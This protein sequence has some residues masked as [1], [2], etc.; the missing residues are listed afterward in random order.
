MSAKPI[1]PRG[2]S[3]RSRAAEVHNLSEKVGLQFFL[4]GG[5]PILLNALS[6]RRNTILQTKL[7][8]YVKIP[9]PSF[10]NPNSKFKT[11]SYTSMQSEILYI[12]NSI[13]ILLR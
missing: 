3:K 11:K 7:G 9:K 1:P 8:G 12:P 10:R 2:S 6:M 5:H 4:R 13:D